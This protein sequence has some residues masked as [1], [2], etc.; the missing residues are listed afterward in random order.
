[1]PL[2][3]EYEMGRGVEKLKEYVE[4]Q[5]RIPTLCA[6]LMVRKAHE[7]HGPANQRKERSHQNDRANT[8]IL[9]GNEHGTI[10]GALI[11][12]IVRDLTARKRRR[13]NHDK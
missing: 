5:P 4:R 11:V 9:N 12:D 1:M 6:S 2:L 3:P 7:Y 13:P 8:Y 10:V